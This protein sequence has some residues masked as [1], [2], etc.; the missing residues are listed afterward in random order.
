MTTNDKNRIKAIEKIK[1][2]SE[3][4]E[5]N[6]AFSGEIAAASSRIQSLMNKYAIEWAEIYVSQEND[7]AEKFI[8]ASAD[9]VI[10]RTVAWHWKLARIISRITHTKHYRNS[11]YSA[12]GV[13]KSADIYNPNYKK[14]KNPKKAYSYKT[15]GFYGEEN[16]AKFAS[17]L[18]AKWLARIDVESL[19]AMKKAKSANKNI[20]ARIFRKSF[21]DGCVE[22]MNERIDEENAKMNQLS[23]NALAVVDSAVNEAYK[24]FSENFGTT[25]IGR[26]RTYS[27]EGYANGKLYGK[28]INLSAKEI[29]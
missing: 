15:F 27:A 5:D 21:L 12:E 24:K 19:I 11:K 17:E 20:D 9:V 25:S 6:G 22:G 29:K 8:N 16:S 7:N 23:S 4:T 14:L 18:F 2:M 28:S 26:N 3:I 13:V 10:S 1:L